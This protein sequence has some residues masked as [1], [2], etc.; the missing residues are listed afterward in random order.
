MEDFP[1]LNIGT[2]YTFSV[3]LAKLEAL[4]PFLPV[5]LPLNI[6]LIPQ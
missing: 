2:E 5:T 1:N 6:F 4:F 3:F